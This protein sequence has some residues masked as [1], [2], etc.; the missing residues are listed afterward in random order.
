L[1]NS[2]RIAFGRYMRIL[3]QHKGLSIQEV[4]RVLLN[5]SD[6]TD[7]GSLSRL[8]RGQQQLAAGKLAALCRVYEVSPEVPLER[9]DLDHAVDLHV[10]LDTDGKSTEEL[11]AV[12][13][14]ALE[15]AERWQA[16]ACFRDALLVDGPD[17]HAL[18][19]NLA[20]TARALGRFRFAL[21]EFKV[22]E[23]DCRDGPL[24]PAVLERMAST[25][26]SIGDL[27]SAERLAW[28]SA[29]AARSR[30]DSRILGYAFASLANVNLARLGDPELTVDYLNMAHRAGRESG[31]GDG[32]LKP[33]AN[34]EI[35][36][37][38]ALA[39]SYLEM[40]REESARRAATAALKLS[41]Q[42][43]F[44]VGRGYAQLYLGQVD[45]SCGRRER[46]EER[47]REAMAIAESAENKRLRFCA[48]FYLYRQ[49]LR[50][51]EITRSK[52]LGRGLQRLAP[53]V[54]E[55][56]PLLA[57]FRSL[58]AGQA[59]RTPDK[60]AKSRPASATTVLRRSPR[61]EPPAD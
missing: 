17:D 34:F 8:E 37:L 48:M 39:E 32:A 10:D 16:Y 15:R 51:G 47:W 9:L 29:E 5:A 4:C 43:G 22:L 59:K 1:A 38:H 55:N 24:H 7:A 6:G 11:L 30:G 26:R 42:H 57:E 46:A 2:A 28:A 49:A 54:P 23:E 27:D 20:T 14:E 33:N 60:S 56:L 44:S 52:A 21:H 3:R 19:F 40:G 53:W 13:R 31:E 45:E 25:L 36:T 12:G 41:E 18:R 58:A 61:T 35:T 50:G